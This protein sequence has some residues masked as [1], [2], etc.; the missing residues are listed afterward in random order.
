MRYGFRE[1]LASLPPEKR[2]SD[3]TVSRF[4]HRPL[5][6]PIAWI[7]LNA[8]VTPNQATYVSAFLCV[9]GLAL[10]LVPVPAAHWVA[11]ACFFSFGTL[12]CVDGTMARTI[13]AKDPNAGSGP[14]GEWVDALGGYIAYATILIALG[15]SA[16]LVAA[17]VTPGP[18]SW[19]PA[20]SWTII[21]AIA[22]TANLVM[23]LAFQSFRVVSGDAGR[24]GVAG[25]KRLSEE[26]GI[27]GWLQPLYAVGLATGFLPYVL[28]AYAAIFIG[29]GV[30][31]VARLAKKA[32][33]RR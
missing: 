31:T 20:G 28:F 27:T 9:A 23:R 5:S 1:V 15:R 29:G 8:G 26:I 3:G 22:S 24:S 25:E 21:G 2:R 10:A 16:D 32:G 12:D 18:A 7:L 11:V 13:R 17:R 33:S 19:V 14:W 6:Y 4:L 30:I